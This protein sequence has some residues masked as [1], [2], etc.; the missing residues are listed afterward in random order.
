MA[1]QHGHSQWQRATECSAWRFGAP[2]AGC[3]PPRAAQR[4][5]SA[6]WRP[7]ETDLGRSEYRQLPCTAGRP[8][9]EGEGEG[10]SQSRALL[11]AER[12]AHHMP[13]NVRLCETALRQT[14]CGWAARFAASVY[15]VAA[16]CGLSHFRWQPAAF[17]KH[18][19]ASFPAQAS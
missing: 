11:A 12:V 9:D 17:S 1:P 6:A 16:S 14:M 8:L 18:M 10:R 2:L 4:S 7:T 19:P 3:P 13:R 15:A 5:L